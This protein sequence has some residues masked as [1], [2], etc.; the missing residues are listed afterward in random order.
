MPDRVGYAP[1]TDQQRWMWSTIESTAGEPLGTIVT[2]TFHDHTG[3]HVPI[4]VEAPSVLADAYS[5]RIHLHPTPVVARVST[6][7]PLL[8]SPIKSCLVRESSVAQFLTAQGAPVVAPSDILPPHHYD[9]LAITFWTTFNPY[10]MPI[11]SLPVT[12]CYCEKHMI[13]CCLS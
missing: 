10:R 4:R 1:Q 9:G 12:C 2:I 6:L 13:G 11:S 5:V 3:F 8:R 7:T